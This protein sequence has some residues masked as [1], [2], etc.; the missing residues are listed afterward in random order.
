MTVLNDIS[1]PEEGLALLAERPREEIPEQAF[2]RQFWTFIFEE[3]RDGLRG[4]PLAFGRALLA[5]SVLGKMRPYGLVNA[6]LA[7]EVER[8]SPKDHQDHSYFAQHKARYE[9]VR[10]LVDAGMSQGR[11][12]D[13]AADLLAKEGARGEPR[14]MRES[15][16]I[17]F[18]AGGER[19][20][21]T[22]IA[23][24]GSGA[25]PSRNKPR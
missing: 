1:D 18:D 17:I 14:T 20:S 13:A 11:A 22:P 4:D 5:C 15:F 2:L 7:R 21:L 16:E 8:M 10:A 19:T 23:A 9:A 12:Y 6:V 3:W 24:P 25:I